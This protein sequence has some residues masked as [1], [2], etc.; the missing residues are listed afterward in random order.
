VFKGEADQTVA[1]L[2]SFSRSRK[3]VKKVLKILNDKDTADV[4]SSYLRTVSE[5]WIDLEFVKKIEIYLEN[6]IQHGKN[7]SSSKSLRK[8]IFISSRKSKGL[9]GNLEDRSIGK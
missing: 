7:L 9:I 3:Y 8:N 2:L 1:F 6:T 4:V 5:E